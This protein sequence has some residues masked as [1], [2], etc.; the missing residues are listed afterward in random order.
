MSGKIGGGGFAFNRGI[1]RNNYFVRLAVFN[2]LHQIRDPQLFGTNAMDRRNRSMQNVINAIVMPCLLYRGDIGRLF[3]YAD[4][5]LV[6]SC[7][8]AIG[9]GINVGDVVTYRAQT[10]AGLHV[11]DG[12][13]KGARIV[14]AGTQNVK[15]K[16]LRR[17][18]SNAG[19]F[20]ELVNQTG[21]GFGETR[22]KN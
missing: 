20:F 14:F 22:H 15:C 17:F 12:A 5:V 16:P 13:G 3:D 9:A 19:K 2:P 21:H 11:M 7:A 18:A 6:S 8:R 10:Q 4:Q 1:G